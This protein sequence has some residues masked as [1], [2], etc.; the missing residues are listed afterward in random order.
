MDLA[1]L[2]AWITGD[3]NGAWSDDRD[4]DREPAPRRS[5]L[6]ELRAELTRAESM[7]LTA[8]GTRVDMWR[9]EVHNLSR[10]IATRTLGA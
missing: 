10:L 3:S 4:D 1:A 5:T 9:E 8:A 2:D 6:A 7:V